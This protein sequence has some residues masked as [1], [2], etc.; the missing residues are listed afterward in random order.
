MMGVQPNND[1]ERAAI[2]ERLIQED[3]RLAREQAKALQ[4]GPDGPERGVQP[5][6]TR[7]LG[8][9]VA[10]AARRVGP[11]M[12]RTAP[13]SQMEHGIVRTLDTMI[14]RL[15]AEF[16]EMPGLRLTSEQVQRLCGVERIVCQMVLDALVDAKFLSRKPDG[17]YA[18]L[19]AHRIEPFKRERL[20]GKASTTT[21]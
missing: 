16:M 14:E 12:A 5:A 9:G 15:R 7:S 3:R 18:P 17:A 10:N 21:R 19:T 6:P 20:T 8:R 11:S 13:T 1:E 2:V 4:Q